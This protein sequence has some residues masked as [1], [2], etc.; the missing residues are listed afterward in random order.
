MKW[1]WEPA[2]YRKELGDIILARL[3]IEQR[4]ISVNFGKRLT[5]ENITSLLKA[6]KISLQE[7]LVQWEYLQQKL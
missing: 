7:N 6:D 3:L 1:F 2:H 4:G 5:T